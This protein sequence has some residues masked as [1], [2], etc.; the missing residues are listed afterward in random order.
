LPETEI[1]VD[2]EVIPD[3]GLDGA[4]VDRVVETSSE[5]VEIGIEGGGGEAAVEGGGEIIAAALEG[6]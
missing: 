5:V 6:V 1:D 3:A 2:T 4:E